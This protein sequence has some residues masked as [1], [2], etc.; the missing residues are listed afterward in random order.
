MSSSDAHNTFGRLQTCESQGPAILASDEHNMET[1]AELGDAETSRTSSKRSMN[2]R[3]TVWKFFKKVKVP[4]S[5][6]SDIFEEKAKCIYCP[7]KLSCDSK[8]NG[9]NGLRYHIKICKENL[10][11]RQK[12]VLSYIPPEGSRGDETVG[13]LKNWNFDQ[14]AVRK[15]LAHMVMVDELPFRFVERVGFQHFMRVACPLF[16]IPSRRTLGRDCYILYDEERSKLKA[17]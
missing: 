11:N 12:T 17:F 2:P 10:L 4:I 1:E 15:A 13:T 8:R 14:E 3:S 9:T 6:S 7:A 16:S 5:G